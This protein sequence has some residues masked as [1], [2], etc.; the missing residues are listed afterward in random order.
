MD[1]GLERGRS[2]GMI[3][4]WRR[5]DRR[6]ARRRSRRA[7]GWQ[8]CERGIQR[9]LHRGLHNDG[10]CG[11]VREWGPSRRQHGCPGWCEDRDR[12]SG[13]GWRY[14]CQRCLNRRL[15]GGLDSRR[16]GREVRDDDRNRRCGLRWCWRCGL[17]RDRCYRC[18]SLAGG[19]DGGQRCADRCL[20]LTLHAG[21]YGGERGCWRER[22][23]QRGQGYW[24][25]L[26]LWR[27]PGH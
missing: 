19:R 14:G 11:Q 21:C 13:A 1:S 26:G 22:S 24:G 16:G 12:G 10:G 17:R 15:N 8:G 4:R 27:P 23:L 7:R 5:R 6:W 2:G 3:R 25:W 9:R 18:G 20:H